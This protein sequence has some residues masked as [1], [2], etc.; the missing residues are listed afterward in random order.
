MSIYNN[1]IRSAH[2]VARAFLVANL[3][4]EGGWSGWNLDAGRCED[5]IGEVLLA[6][7]KS[8]PGALTGSVKPVTLSVPFGADDRGCSHGISGIFGWRFAEALTA[9]GR[10]LMIDVDYYSKDG[11][12]YFTDYRLSLV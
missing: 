11:N 5:G 7:A 12:V 8:V 9:D 1:L 6:V 2:S 4:R 10:T 3:A